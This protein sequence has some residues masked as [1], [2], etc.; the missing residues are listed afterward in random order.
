M[1]S[2]AIAEIK[3]MRMLGL[4]FRSRGIIRR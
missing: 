1:F 3:A 4:A 2:Y